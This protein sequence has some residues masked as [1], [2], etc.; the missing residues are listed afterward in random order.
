MFQPSQDLSLCGSVTGDEGAGKIIWTLLRIE[1]GAP[2]M[3]LVGRS[4]AWVKI[5]FVEAVDITS[6]E[7]WP[8]CLSRN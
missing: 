7:P 8:S 5:V 2:R 4:E 3:M 6:A 1:W